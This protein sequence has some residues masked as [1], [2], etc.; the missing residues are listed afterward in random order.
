MLA[1]EGTAM[2]SRLLVQ[3]QGVAMPSGLMHRAA[4]KPIVAMPFAHSV[5]YRSRWWLAV[6]VSDGATA[7]MQRR[8]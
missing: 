1:V 5:A 6:S 8:W 3:L 2:H 4:R 7:V